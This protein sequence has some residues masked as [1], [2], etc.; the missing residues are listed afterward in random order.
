MTCRQTPLPV[1]GMPIDNCHE[2]GTAF[3]RKTLLY[4]TNP[5][6][7]RGGVLPHSGCSA[8]HI[9]Y[10]KSVILGTLGKKALVL[11]L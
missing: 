2:D 9:F 7:I 1:F 11:G 5:L 3:L 10:V 4:L 8:L 6:N